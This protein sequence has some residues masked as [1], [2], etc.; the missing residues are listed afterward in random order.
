V[1]NEWEKQLLDNSSKENVLK[2]VLAWNIRQIDTFD[3]CAK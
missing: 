3:I 2:N 1:E